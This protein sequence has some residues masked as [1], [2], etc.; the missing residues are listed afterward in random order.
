M[1][2][3]PEAKEAVTLSSGGV[4]FPFSLNVKHGNIKLRML[5]R[6]R[7]DH[8]LVFPIHTVAFLCRDMDWKVFYLTHRI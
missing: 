8:R 7:I 1:S 6:R 4:A 3:L 2:L 5:M